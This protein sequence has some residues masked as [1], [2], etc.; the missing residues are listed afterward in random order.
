MRRARKKAQVALR[1]FYSARYSRLFFRRCSGLCRGLLEIGT[2]LIRHGHNRARNF[3]VCQVG[4]AA[5]R[6]HQ[7]DTF[8]RV[9]RQVI[10]AVRDVRTSARLVAYFRR[11]QGAAA[12][13]SGTH[14]FDHF[15]ARLFDFRRVR[16]SD[17]NLTDRL[18][19]RGN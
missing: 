19:T 6:R 17:L 14:G 11:A 1:L 8:D 16:V 15:L 4:V 3:G 2:R 9:F 7:F 13:A 5:T 12:M 10:Q 18:Q